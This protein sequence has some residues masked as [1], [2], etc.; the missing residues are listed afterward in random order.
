M[1]YRTIH[2]IFH[3]DFSPDSA[4]RIDVFCVIS[5]DKRVGPRTHYKYDMFEYVVLHFK[6][7]QLQTKLEFLLML[8]SLKL[9]LFMRKMRNLEISFLQNVRIHM[10]LLSDN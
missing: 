3:I 2:V 6:G 10:V 1:I 8:R 4:Y 5:V 7:L 9:L